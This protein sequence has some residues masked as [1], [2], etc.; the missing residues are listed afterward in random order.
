VKNGAGTVIA[1]YT[2]DGDGQRLTKTVGSETITYHYFKGQLMYE[3]SNQYADKVTARYTWTSEGKLLSIC[4]F[5]PVEVYW[6]YYYCHYNAHGDV[7]GGGRWVDKPLESLGKIRYGGV[8][9]GVSGIVNTALISANPAYTS[10]QKQQL[11]KRN[12]IFTGLGFVTGVSIGLLIPGVGWG[13][14]CHLGKLSHNL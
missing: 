12:W 14:Y 6:N 9:A 7:V 2:Y 3:T 13:I 4:I 1:S 11:I 10:L 5:R 8:V